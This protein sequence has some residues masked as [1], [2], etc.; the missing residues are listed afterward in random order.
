MKSLIA[1]GLVAGL[2]LSMSPAI[3][4][5]FDAQNFGQGDN[6]ASL[7]HF[8]PQ[9]FPL[10]G[11]PKAGKMNLNNDQLENIYNLKNKLQDDLGPKMI[12]VK[13]Q[14]RHLRDLLTQENLNKDEITATQ[15]Q[16][17]ALKAE[18]ANLRLAF[19]VSMNE[20]LTAEQRQQIRYRKL[21][22]RKMRGKRHH[23]KRMRRGFTGQK[24]V[25]GKA[26]VP[27]Q[28][29]QSDNNLSEISESI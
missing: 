4:Q 6:V 24:S 11:G 14:S 7:P 26:L 9:A 10:G 22:P 12:E 29:V 20:N 1:L 23:Q 3:A 18:I 5:G 8:S 15:N 28:E 16:I 2:S 19:R 17:N 27:Q 21:K 25:I 13:K